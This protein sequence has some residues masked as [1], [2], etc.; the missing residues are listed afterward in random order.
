[1]KVVFINPAL[2]RLIS[3]KGKI[4]NK[5]WPPLCLLNCASI[6]E[7]EGITVELIDLRAEKADYREIVE[8]ASNADK[9]FITTSPLDKWQCPH[10]EIKG[11]FD[12]LMPFKKDNLFIMGVHGTLYPEM[13]LR[14]TNVAA[15]I[16][17]EPEMTVSEICKANDMAGIPGVSYCRD[18]QIIHNPDRALLDMDKLPMPAYHLIDINNYRYELV[19]NRF[20]LLETS[21]GC[22]YS[23]IYCFKGMY[24]WRRYRRKSIENVTR[25]IDYVINT[26]GAESLFFVDLEFTLDRDFVSSICDY[27]IQKGYDITW[28][29]QTRA[30]TVDEMLLKKMKEAGCSLI[31]FGAE[32]GSERIMDLINKKI[33]LS[34]I[35]KG[36]SMT[37][38]AGI[39]TACFFMFGLPGETLKDME[40]TIKFALKLNP[41]YASFHAAIPYPGTELYRMAGLSENFPEACT[42]D[43][44]I[45]VLKGMV[46]KAFK[47]FYLRPAYIR[48]VLFNGSFSLIRKQFRLFIEFIK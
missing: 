33:S 35:E 19:G 6:I 48:S 18:G 46:R 32:S 24:G 43:Y 20:A 34:E 29:C 21:R 15:V 2:D 30:D 16:R 38:S 45:D 25:E 40:A 14:E 28:C 22:P 17:G 42:T 7:K 8:K 23:C 5:K 1:M 47:Q 13:I 27:I 44:T 11:F 12:F 31:H 36:I 3:K 9:V 4:F 10:L 41:T 26:A 39:E 37:K